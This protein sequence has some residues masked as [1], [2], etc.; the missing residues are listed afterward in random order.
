MTKVG[1]GRTDDQALVL[2]TP[3]A[4]HRPQGPH[5]DGI[6]EDRAR[7]M[8]LDVA[9]LGRL[10]PSVGQGFANHC[11]LGKSIRNRQTTAGAI[12]VDR[13]TANKGQY[14]VAVRNRIGEA[15]EHHDPATLC[16]PEA[17]GRC[18]KGLAT[19]IGRQRFELTHG[20]A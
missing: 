11:L 1:L 15:L 18:V 8:G 4:Q 3:L 19:A 20:D 17:V 10:Y 6:A 16:L 5:L 14:V 7:A 2:R 12:M 13:R 9:H